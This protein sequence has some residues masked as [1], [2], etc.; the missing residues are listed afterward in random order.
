MNYENIVLKLS[1]IRHLNLISSYIIRLET[2]IFQKKIQMRFKLI[3]KN[4]YNQLT[5]KQL[6][7]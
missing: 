1:E 7:H 5:L 4:C 2:R 6:V 3:K